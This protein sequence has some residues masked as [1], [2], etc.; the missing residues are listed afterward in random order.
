M[1]LFFSFFPSFGAIPVCFLPRKAGARERLVAFSGCRSCM[2]YIEGNG[3][4]MKYEGTL[5]EEGGMP[6]VAILLI[7]NKIVVT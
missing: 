4:V 2:T 7:I 6:E 1:C 3:R 5:K